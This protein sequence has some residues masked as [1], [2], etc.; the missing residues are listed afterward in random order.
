VRALALILATFFVT[1]YPISYPTPNP[2]R[3][4]VCVHHHHHA[5]LCHRK[6]HAGRVIA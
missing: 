2:P 4:T 6:H 5:N 1:S 3:S